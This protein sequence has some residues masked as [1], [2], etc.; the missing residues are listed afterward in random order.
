MRSG[1][2]QRTETDG[3]PIV[4]VSP[5]WIASGNRYGPP[6]EPEAK[7][8]VR[9]SYFVPSPALTTSQFAPSATDA[10]SVLPETLCK[11]KVIP[12]RCPA[13]TGVVTVAVQRTRPWRMKPLALTVCT[14]TPAGAD[15]G[16]VAE[17]L[18]AW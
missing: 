13:S 8:A 18:V 15:V 17:A 4:F 14:E 9:V 12:I 11:L 5:A 16:G 3:L 1:P 6:S 10:L 7:R 2:F